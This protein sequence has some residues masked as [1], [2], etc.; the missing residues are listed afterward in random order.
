MINNP[1]ES[2]KLMVAERRKRSGV[3][4]AT[5]ART[6]WATAVEVASAVSA[7]GIPRTTCG[8]APDRDRSDR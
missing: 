3:T 4:T 6:R 7:E 2:E 8:S 1:H 5:A